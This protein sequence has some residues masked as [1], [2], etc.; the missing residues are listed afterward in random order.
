MVFANWSEAGR[1]IFGSA[2]Y[3]QCL[4]YEELNI[5]KWSPLFIFVIFFTAMSLF[6][7]DGFASRALAQQGKISVPHPEYTFI[8]AIKYVF[9]QF[10]WIF[11]GDLFF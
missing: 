6:K 7:I 10:L 4:S 9:P 1:Y 2:C 11:M 5:F 8:V 3:Q